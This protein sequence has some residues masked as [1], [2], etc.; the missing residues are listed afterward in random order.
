MLRIGTQSAPLQAGGT[1]LFHAAAL[2]GTGALAGREVAPSVFAAAAVPP[3]PA[4]R[5]RIKALH[6][7]SSDAC[8]AGAV[9]PQLL[10]LMNISFPAAAHASGVDLAG[11]GLLH[12]LSAAEAACGKGWVEENDGQEDGEP[13]NGVSDGEAEA[14]GNSSQSGWLSRVLAA[15][16]DSA[17]GAQLQ[18]AATRAVSSGLL[19]YACLRTS[20]S[21]FRVRAAKAGVTLSISG[22]RHHLDIVSMTRL[23]GGN[24]AHG[25]ALR[26]AINAWQEGLSSIGA[27]PMPGIT[28]VG[29]QPPEVWRSR[30]E[31][32]WP[33][34]APFFEA[35][36]Q[37]GVELRQLANHWGHS[38]RSIE[39]RAWRGR[40][41]NP[42]LVLRTKR[43]PPEGQ[44]GRP[45]GKKKKGAAGKKKK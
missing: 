18:A 23:G 21:T 20:L 37:A 19:S 42:A 41:P 11:G 32:G 5:Q 15:S 31:A 28:V 40:D 6:V 44:D 16:G 3:G 27:G 26:Q 24:L 38:K 39:G 45:P 33:S 2:V 25:A 30:V 9:R 34:A 12:C 4:M 17:A 35:A 14:D 10:R 36:L 22:H 8:A 1:M 13:E 43:D 7:S 29:V